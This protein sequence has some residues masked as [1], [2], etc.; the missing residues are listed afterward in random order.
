MPVEVLRCRICES[1]H[2]AIANGICTRCFGPLEPVY[3]WDAVAQ[4]RHARAD[5]GGAAVALALQQLLPAEP[6]EDS[7]SGPGWTPL[8]P[9]PRLAKRA[10]ASARC[11]SSS[12]SRTRRTRSRTAWSP[13]RRR[14]RG[15]SASRRSRPRPPATSRTRSPRA[16]PRPG[17]T[18]SI[19]CPAGLE[20]EKFQATT[21]YGATVYGVRGSYDDCSRLV[22]ELAGEVD[23]G[24]VNVNLRS[25]YSEG[26]KTL[27]FEIP[28]SSAGRRPTRS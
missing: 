15:S 10:S 26:S 5:R 9:A 6:P 14:R 19:F 1:D 24:I 27:A 28:S 21:V 18:R 22:S 7:A 12:T 3:D 13:S 25:Y 20:P 11:S 16:R 17:S 23:W 8:V 2:P 4:A